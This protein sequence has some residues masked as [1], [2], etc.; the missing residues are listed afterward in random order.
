MGLIKN[1][2]FSTCSD[3]GFFQGPD[4]TLILFKRPLSLLKLN[5]PRPLPRNHL[6]R[7]HWSK[8]TCALTT[9]CLLY[10]T[11]TTGEEA[12]NSHISFT[13][14]KGSPRQGNPQVTREASLIASMLPRHGPGSF[15]HV[16]T[17]FH[18]VNT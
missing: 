14:T 17:P 8:L 6:S 16:F 15:H 1:L 4:S 10:A 13:L 12:E 5:S 7:Q 3:H 11:Q 18:C 9:P 2:P